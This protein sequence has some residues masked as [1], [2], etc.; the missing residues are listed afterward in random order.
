MGE[1]HRS[2]IANPPGKC[3]S[4]NCWIFPVSRIAFCL[5]TLADMAMGLDDDI[6][7]TDSA[8]PSAPL[9]L[10]GFITEQEYARQRGVSV[11]TCQRDRAMR[12]SPPYCALGKQIFY[13]VSAVREWLIRNERSFESKSP[14]SRRPG[15]R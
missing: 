2:G 7:A 12:K 11:R 4:R 8:E 1:I 15:H 9:L 3:I 10:Q 6:P 14:P 13:R 5:G